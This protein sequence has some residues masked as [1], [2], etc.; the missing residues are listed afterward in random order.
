MKNNGGV[1]TAP[2][3][4]FV[5][6][7]RMPP[8]MQRMSNFGLG[9]NFRLPLH[10]GT[11]ETRA[12][13]T[14][15]TKT[16]N[17]EHSSIPCVYDASIDVNRN[18]IEKIERDELSVAVPCN[19]VHPY[20]KDNGHYFKAQTTISASVVPKHVLVEYDNFP[21][22]KTI[23]PEMKV[24]IPPIPSQNNFGRSSPKDAACQ[25]Q[26]PQVKTRSD[27]FGHFSPIR[28]SA[29]QEFSDSD[30]EWENGAMSGF[31]GFM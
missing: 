3:A 9:D 1:T 23:G 28:A 10:N 13:T 12:K 16:G 25:V 21:P 5:Q 17:Y 24:V 2:V 19:T 4:P 30:S 6:Q 11:E 31:G 20:H 22:N 29:S 26:Q 7:N 8:E 27:N 15:P 14:Q 18:I